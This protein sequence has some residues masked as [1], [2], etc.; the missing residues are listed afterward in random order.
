MEVSAVVVLLGPPTQIDWSPQSLSAGPGTVYDLVSGTRT[1]L[2]AF[3]GSTAACLATGSPPP[4]DDI[5]A[6]PARGQVYWYLIRARNSCGN[7]TYGS[8]AMDQSIPACF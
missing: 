8:A 3:N 4:V 7:G 1:G 5:R 2:G 6:D